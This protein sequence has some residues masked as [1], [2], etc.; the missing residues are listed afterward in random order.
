MY[1]LSCAKYIKSIYLTWIAYFSLEYIGI[2]KEY[3]PVILFIVDIETEVQRINLLVLVTQ[4]SQYSTEPEPSGLGLTGAYTYL[5]ICFCNYVYVTVAREKQ[6]V[7]CI[8]KVIFKR[9][10]RYLLWLL[11]CLS[12]FL[13]MFLRDRLPLVFRHV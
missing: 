11:L 6:K 7:I 9:R 13:L 5:H 3:T 1:N 8:E 10:G 12:H 4:E 2:G